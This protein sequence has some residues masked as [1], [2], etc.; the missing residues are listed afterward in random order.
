MGWLSLT[1]CILSL[2][3]MNMSSIFCFVGCKEIMLYTDVLYRG[4]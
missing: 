4:A 3:M 1:M 2:R